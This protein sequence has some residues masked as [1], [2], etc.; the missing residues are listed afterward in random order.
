[1]DLN[2]FQYYLFNI[3]LIIN[4]LKMNIRIY[5]TNLFY[6]NLKTLYKIHQPSQ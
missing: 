5:T 2:L 4:I 3:K 6:L 1:M